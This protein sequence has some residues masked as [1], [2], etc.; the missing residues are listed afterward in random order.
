VKTIIKLLITLVVLN[1]VWR[2]G[3][4]AWA[5]Y[6]FKDATQQ[7]LVFGGGTPVNTLH[8]EIMARA[9]EFDVPVA[10]ENV[11]V[12]RE[13]SRTW[14]EVAYTQPVELFPRYTYPMDFQFRVESFATLGI[15]NEPNRR[16]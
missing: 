3:S 16:R 5:Y 12:Q 11:S 4:V 10:A 2:A 15:S 6:Q 9:A 7:A 1:A 14:A 8:M 13:G